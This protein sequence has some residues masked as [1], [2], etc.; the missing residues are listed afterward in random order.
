[1]SGHL[2]VSRNRAVSDLDV[3]GRRVVSGDGDVVSGRRVGDSG[4]LA[5]ELVIVMPALLLLLALIYAYGR[6]AQVTGTLESGVRDASRAA[7]QARD[8]VEAETTAEQVIRDAV[9]PG[10]TACLAT[11]DVAPIE[12]FE[13]GFPVTVRASCRYP[14]GD[15]GLPGLP[16]DVTASAVFSSPLDPNRGVR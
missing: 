8:V 1:V 7:T 6:V 3:T 16:G 10:A 13:P 11:L 4:T 2:A 9:G 15:L 5:L 14:L 12:V